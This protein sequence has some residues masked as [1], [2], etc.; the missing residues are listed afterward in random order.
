MGMAN[1]LHASTHLQKL[2]KH[3]EKNNEIKESY[4]RINIP[5]TYP[6]K[7]NIAYGA[8]KNN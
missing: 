3:E 5:T 7:Q 6:Q 2:N 1:K 4:M 8:K